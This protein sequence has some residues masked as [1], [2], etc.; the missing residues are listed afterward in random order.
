[1]MIKCRLMSV[2]FDQQGTCLGE[3]NLVMSID[4]WSCHEVPPVN[5]PRSASPSLV[6]TI[7]SS[8]FETLTL[9]T[10]HVSPLLWTCMSR[11]EL[12]SNTHRSFSTSAS[13]QTSHNHRK[14]QR[15][16]PQII[17]P[18]RPGSACPVSTGRRARH[19]ELEAAQHQRPTSS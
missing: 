6:S 9:S 1:M 13:T 7:H 15:S 16:T 8:P 12:H 11:A 18:P 4:L 2:R 3:P 14:E 19:F 17:A 5:R 10:L